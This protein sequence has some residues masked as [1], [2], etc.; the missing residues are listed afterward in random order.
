M[1]PDFRGFNMNPRNLLRIKLSSVPSDVLE[2]VLSKWSVDYWND[3]L[4]SRCDMCKYVDSRLPWEYLQKFD[5]FMCPLGKD[6][7]CNGLG[8]TS[9][10]HKMYHGYNETF[11][12]QDVEKFRKML[13]AELDRRNKEGNLS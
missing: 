8:R 5:C 6:S 9:R 12:K 7:W 1:V 10:L 11:W 3:S 4:W 2:S 13:Q